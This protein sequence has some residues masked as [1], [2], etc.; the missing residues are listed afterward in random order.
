MKKQE[1]FLFSGGHQ[2]YYFSN[3]AYMTAQEYNNF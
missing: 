3:R 2:S 1:S